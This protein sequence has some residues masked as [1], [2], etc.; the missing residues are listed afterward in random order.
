M[1]QFIAEKKINSHFLYKDEINSNDEYQIIFHTDKNIS[2]ENQI[3]DINEQYR[4][5]QQSLPSSVKP[6]IKRYFLSD[7]SNQEHM[8]NLLES[9]PECAVS[10]IQQPP[11]DGSKV[12][13]WV[14]F[15]SDVNLKKKSGLWSYAHNGYTHIWTANKKVTSGDSYQQC[16]E[17]FSIYDA[18]L[19]ENGI[20]V[21]KNCIRT[22]LYVQ[23]V[24]VNYKGVVEGRKDFFNDI[25]L[26]NKTH[27]IASTG[28]EGRVADH[29]S[30]MIF[31]AY[32]IEGVYSNQIQYLYAPEN[33]NPTY[34]Y[35]VT[36][37]RG[38]AVHYGDRS[39]VFISGT[40]SINNKGEIVAPGDIKRQIKRTLENVDALL[41][42]A[43]C[44]FDNISSMFVYLRDVADYDV[45]RKMF[46]NKFPNTPKVIV[47][48][49]V[50]RPGWLIEMECI[51]IRKNDNP[52][53]RQY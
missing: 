24:D 29:R 47:L 34:E 17:L 13:L 10:I 32:A 23:N 14:W 3:N 30:L 53:F 22:W 33:L 39:H 16:N 28:I 21:E 46:D 25:N 50:C 7:A 4:V 31:D 51:A 8:V 42:E 36:F 45:A 48:A 52:S 43:E 41:N 11:L 27:Y 44:S 12:A 26:T 9:D 6:V 37:E 2:F 15:Q 18:S 40:A 35:G 5:Y 19:K 1:T 20:S 49:P 38:T